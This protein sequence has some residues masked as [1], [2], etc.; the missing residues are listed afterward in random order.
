[1]F[2]VAAGMLSGC[3]GDEGNSKIKVPPLGNVKGTIKLDDKPLANAF[4]EFVIP[5]ARGSSART[6]SNGAYTLMY[7]QDTKGAAVG[8]HTV[9]IIGRTEAGTPEPVP[10][11]YNER[12]ELKATVKPGENTV[13]FSLKSK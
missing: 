4:V 13:D 2:V 7:D 6:D 11:K 3:G 1:M 8:E 5:T 9:K 12:S 10:A